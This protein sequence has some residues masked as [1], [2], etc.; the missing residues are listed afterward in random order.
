MNMFMLFGLKA[1]FPSGPSDVA[2]FSLISLGGLI[3]SRHPEGFL[4]NGARS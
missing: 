1:W 3:D 4:M 2:H